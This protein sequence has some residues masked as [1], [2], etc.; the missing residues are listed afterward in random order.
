MPATTTRRAFHV[1][2][3]AVAV[4]GTLLHIGL[5]VA[6]VGRVRL[7]HAADL[8]VL[9]G[10]LLLSEQRPLEVQRRGERGTITLSA[11]FACA[12]LL[13]GPGNMFG[14]QRFILFLPL[15]LFWTGAW[16][17]R[18]HRAIKWVMASVLLVFS[19]A[20]T[21]IGA[22]DPCPRGG[23]DRYTVAQAISNLVRAPEAHEQPPAVLAGR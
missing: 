7:H 11:I 3:A 22:T 2:V 16:M 13:T 18:P 23:Y 4:L 15:L 8:L 14:P 12:I 10:L 1:H 20:V 5:L 19:A 21:I 9:A 17:R 6:A